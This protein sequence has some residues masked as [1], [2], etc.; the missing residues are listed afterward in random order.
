LVKDNWSPLFAK[1]NVSVALEHHTHRYGRTFMLLG[2]KVYE[3]GTLHV[4]GGGWGVPASSL[5]EP[6]PAYMEKVVIKQH[7]LHVALKPHNITVCAL[8]SHGRS[9]DTVPVPL[10]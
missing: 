5:T 3:N 7:I 2:Q 10:R 8:D 6:P 9:F 1:Y 4:G